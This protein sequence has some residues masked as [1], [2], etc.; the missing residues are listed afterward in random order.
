VRSGRGEAGG[1][2]VLK[3]DLKGAR[4]KGTLSVSS[5]FVLKQLGKN[6]QA[7]SFWKM[8]N[9]RLAVDWPRRG[10]SAFSFSFSFSCGGAERA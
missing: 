9:D 2:Y 6:C 10:N 8:R 1:C 4:A 7:P 3:L 5:G